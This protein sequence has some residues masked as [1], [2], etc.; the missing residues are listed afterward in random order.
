LQ[1]AD[2]S[3]WFLA[4][5]FSSVALFYTAT[6]LRKK[7][8]LG[9]SPVIRGH[10][11]TRHRLI[12]DV[13][14]VFRAAILLVCLIRVPFPQIDVWLVPLP[15]MWHPAVI[16]SGCALM[17][18]SFAAIIWL[19]NSMG[20]D[21]RSGINEHGDGRSR[22]IERGAFAWSRNPMFI[23]IQ[24]AQLG[25][26]LALPTIFTLV[27]LIVGIAAIHAQVRLEERHLE[28]RFGDT[29]RSYA[30]RVPRWIIR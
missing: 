11:G 6:I 19:H 15:W 2:L 25:L 9:R 3:R 14:V 1:A 13:F 17:L 24:L 12:H 28:A 10:K 18:A 27:C 8:R 26:F 22:L 21:W 7:R 4:A 23:C 29:W 5:F 30:A 20:A 16:V